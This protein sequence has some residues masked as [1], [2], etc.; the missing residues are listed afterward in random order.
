MRK[1]AAFSDENLEIDDSFI[2]V[3]P[4]RRDGGGCLPL[5][6]D[7][8]EARPV[9]HQ[10]DETIREH[11]LLPARPLDIWFVMDQRRRPFP[12]PELFKSAPFEFHWV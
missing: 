12:I 2:E 6:E 3:T 5:G 1:D 4:P 7:R 11:L 10:V 8:L 9:Y